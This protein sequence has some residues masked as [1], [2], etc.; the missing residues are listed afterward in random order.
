MSISI[1]SHICTLATSSVCSPGEFVL[2]WSVM[3][4]PAEFDWR[5]NEELAGGMWDGLEQKFWFRHRRF[6]R[7]QTQLCCTK[8]NYVSAGQHTP[9]IQFCSLRVATGS[10]WKS[11]QSWPRAVNIASV[12]PRMCFYIIEWCC[13]V[14]CSS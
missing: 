8:S 14:C 3:F 6:L 12:R 5:A 2:L 10:L 11:S 13:C 9:S 1:C 7:S 4:A